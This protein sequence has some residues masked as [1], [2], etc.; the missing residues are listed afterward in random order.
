MVK[1]ELFLELNK[2]YPL[3]QNVEDAPRNSHN[4]QIGE[5]S[6]PE[7]RYSILFKE[8]PVVPKAL[9]VVFLEIVF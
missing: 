9:L 5:L 7:L 1:S 3:Q 6:L 2:L 4:Q 8:F